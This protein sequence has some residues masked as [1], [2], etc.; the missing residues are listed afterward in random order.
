MPIAL[1]SEVLYEEIDILYGATCVFQEEIGLIG[2]KPATLGDGVNANKIPPLD[3]LNLVNSRDKDGLDISSTLDNKNRQPG[4]KLTAKSKNC[5]TVSENVSECLCHQKAMSAN[6]LHPQIV[7]TEPFHDGENS[8]CGCR[9]RND[10]GSSDV[11]DYAT[12]SSVSE[13][14]DADKDK[15]KTPIVVDTSVIRDMSTPGKEPEQQV[16]SYSSIYHFEFLVA[17]CIKSFFRTLAVDSRALVPKVRQIRRL[18]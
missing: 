3:L 1:S 13:R 6:S 2:F 12:G 14:L 11:I 9:S 7:T 17:L 16:S 10:T 5:D 18:V 8:K 15:M 4:K